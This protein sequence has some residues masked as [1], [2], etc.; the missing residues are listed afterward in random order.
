MDIVVLGEYEKCSVHTI[1]GLICLWS[2]VC[3]LNKIVMFKLQF[4]AIQDDTPFSSLTQIK[5]LK[6]VRSP[7][8]D[9]LHKNEACPGKEIKET[10]CL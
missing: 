8:H 9:N 3:R 7:K 4:L 2:T 10:A 1:S 5:V 6:V